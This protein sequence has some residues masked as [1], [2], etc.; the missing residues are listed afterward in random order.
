M[1]FFAFAIFCFITVL[2]AWA[3]TYALDHLV[4]GHPPII[5]TIIWGLAVVII[6]VRLLQASG[7]LSY[8]PVIP[9]F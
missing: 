9:H 4:P 8:D 1:G 6:V 2:I 3:V 7:L 5:N